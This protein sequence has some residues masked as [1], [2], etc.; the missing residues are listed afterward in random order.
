LGLVAALINPGFA[1]SSEPDEGEDSA[2]A[3]AFDQADMRAVVEGDYALLDPDDNLIR[4]TVRQAPTAAK[5]LGSS[6]RLQCGNVERS[7]VAPAGACFTSYWSKLPVVATIE[8]ESAF[9]ASGE[10][11]GLFTVDGLKL[12]FAEL[13]L[14]IGADAHVLGSYFDGKFAD[15]TFRADGV[16]SFVPLRPRGAEASGSADAGQ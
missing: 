10:Y 5:Q 2:P 15:W 3:W 8:S 13:S 16:G 14:D 1:C 6:L 9:I 11:Q 7:F 4:V 12:Q